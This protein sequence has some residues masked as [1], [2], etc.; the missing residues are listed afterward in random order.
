MNGA[1]ARFWLGRPKPAH[2]RWHTRRLAVLALLALATRAPAQ[3]IEYLLQPGSVLRPVCQSCALAKVGKQALNGTFNLTVMPLP[4]A[5]TIE[6]V[7]AVRWYGEG[8]RI[9]G[10]GFLQRRGRNRISMV[11]DAVVN[12]KPVLLTSSA[13]PTEED[14][15]F[16]IALA[17]EKASD[18][19]V[20]IDLVA[21]ASSTDAAD[22]DGDGTPDFLDLCP[23]H[24]EVRHFDTDHDGVGD[25]CDECA[26]TTLGSP[27]LPNGCSPTQRCPCAGPA[28]NTPWKNQRAYIT[29]VAQALKALAISEELTR[30]QVRKLMQ[31]AIRS[32]CGEPVV[33]MR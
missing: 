16:R 1:P 3:T 2:K 9:S 25:P 5:H 7:T 19:R 32:G 17:S 33:A 28:P 8:I 30:S 26:G 31:A 22:A 23:F 15:S 11:V 29:C 21:L 14:G 10:S 12:G 13:H 27:V 4:D 24:H 18:L 20:E 6:A